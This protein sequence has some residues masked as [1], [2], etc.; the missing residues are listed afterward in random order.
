MEFVLISP[1][2]LQQLHGLV[3]LRVPSHVALQAVHVGSGKVATATP[4]E[5]EESS[6]TRGDEE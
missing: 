6:Q 1:V 4:T 2:L 5:T 3:L